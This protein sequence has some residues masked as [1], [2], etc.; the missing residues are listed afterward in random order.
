MFGDCEV[1]NASV[2]L[3]KNNAF[4]LFPAIGRLGYVGVPSTSWLK[5][6]VGPVTPLSSEFPSKSHLWSGFNSVLIHSS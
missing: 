3:S 6:L 1:S 4:E 5:S 2:I